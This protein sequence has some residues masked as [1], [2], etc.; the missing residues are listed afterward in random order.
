LK[1]KTNRRNAKWAWRGAGG[2]IGRT[3]IRSWKLNYRKKGF[4]GLRGEKEKKKRRKLKCANGEARQGSR[5]T[6]RKRLGD[7]VIKGE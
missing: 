7:T 6:S 1:K 2:Y 4:R 5:L 3:Q